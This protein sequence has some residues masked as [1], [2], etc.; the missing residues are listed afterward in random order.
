LCLKPQQDGLKGVKKLVNKLIWIPAMLLWTN[1]YFSDGLK[2]G[3]GFDR[4]LMGGLPPPA[5]PP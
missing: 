1:K 5:F 2:L 3:L 4:L